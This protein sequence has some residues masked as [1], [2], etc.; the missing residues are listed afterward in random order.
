[1]APAT[2]DKERVTL[3]GGLDLTQ[4]QELMGKGRLRGAYH[5]KFEDFI[6]SDES[7]VDVAEAWPLEFGQKVA[8]TLYQGFNNVVSKAGLG[9]TVKV[10]NREGKV[11]LVHMERYGAQQAS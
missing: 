5:D 6:N 2:L 8:T 4:I 9:D 11:Y 3:S 10:I 1:M 7:A